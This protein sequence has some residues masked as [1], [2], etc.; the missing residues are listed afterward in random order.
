MLF[1]ISFG[2]AD[3]SAPT[4]DMTVGRIDLAESVTFHV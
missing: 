2:F 3:S 4:N 1:G